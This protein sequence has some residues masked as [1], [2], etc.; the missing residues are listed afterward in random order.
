MGTAQSILKA[1]PK[2]V[3]LTGKDQANIADNVAMK[4]V[5]GFGNCR[6]LGYPPTAAAT[7]AHHG[8]LTPMP[9][10]PDT[11]LKWSAVDPNS[12]I[13]GEPALLKPSILQCRHGGTITIINSGQDRETKVK[14]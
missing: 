2:N 11:C 10:V 12:M 9:C 6:S 14:K 8:H 1:T 5:P 7:A 13:C 3:T 4:N